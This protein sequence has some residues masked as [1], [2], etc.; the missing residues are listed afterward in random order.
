MLEIRRLFG[1]RKT[2]FRVA[3]IRRLWNALGNCL[4]KKTNGKSCWGKPR[5]LTCILEL[6]K[7]HSR[8]AVNNL[9][10]RSCN[11]RALIRDSNNS[12]W[13]QTLATRACWFP[14]QECKAAI[15]TLDLLA[16]AKWD[17]LY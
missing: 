3:I 16:R 7:R 17:R 11:K 6:A 8:I 14:K 15:K 2:T 12:Q 13:Q 4:A 5:A 9:T 10:I 1:S